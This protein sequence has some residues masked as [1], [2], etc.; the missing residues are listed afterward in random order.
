LIA[1]TVRN[2]EVTLDRYDFESGLEKLFGQWRKLF[3]Y[4]RKLWGS[5]GCVIIEVGEVEKD[6]HGLGCGLVEGSEFLEA[7]V[8]VHEHIL[9]WHDVGPG[10]VTISNLL[11]NTL[12]S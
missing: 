8:F 7:S 12:V 5:D 10:F 6:S 1:G 4:E 3:L 2:L 11:V 9:Q